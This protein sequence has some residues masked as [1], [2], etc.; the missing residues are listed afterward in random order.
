MAQ[1]HIEVPDSDIIKFKSVVG[2]RRVSEIIRNFIHSYTQERDDLQISILRKQLSVLGPQKE[3]LNSE[4]EAIKAR[5][6]AYDEE[7]RLQEL[8]ELQEL[9]EEKK[10]WD[11][12]RRKTFRDN[13]AT[14]INR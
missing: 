4:Y 3:A 2:D 5:V 10:N 11:E 12:A 7:T 8:R 1:I 14:M 9:Q 6:D 13:A